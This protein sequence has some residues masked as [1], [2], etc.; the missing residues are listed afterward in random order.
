M[1]KR[2]WLVIMMMA[3]AGSS[4]SGAGN[5]MLPL[6]G[7][8]YLPFYPETDKKEDSPKLSVE[9]GPFRLDRNPVSNRRFLE[10][11]QKNPAWRKSRVKP[12]FADEKYLQHW[13]GDLKTERGDLDRPVVNV[14]WFAAAAYCEARD[15]ELPTTDQ[16]EYALAD[17]GRDQEKIQ[18]RILDWYA[19]PTG[20]IPKAGLQPPNGFGIQDLTGPVWEWTSDFNSFLASSDSRNGDQSALFCGGGSLGA[21]DSRDYASFMRYSF[22]G[23][24][25]GRFTGKNLGFRCAKAMR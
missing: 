5:T 19:K 8:S 12:I 2:L 25:Q 17:Q 3:A 22:R 14:S 7:G 16:W 18:R 4:V 1:K 10:F 23:S 6:P 24:L 9:V 15:A 11:V 13:L 21:S 20:R